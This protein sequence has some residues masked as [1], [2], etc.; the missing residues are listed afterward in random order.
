V[1]PG[2]WRLSWTIA[3]GTFSTS[4]VAECPDVAPECAQTVIE[5]HE[6]QARLGLTHTELVAAYGLA[7]DV[8][9]HLIVPYDVKAMN[10]RYT[11]LDGEPF[12]PP[13]GDIHHRTETLRGISDAALIVDWR[14]RPQWVAG[15]GVSLPVGRTEE[16]PVVLGR[17]GKQHQHIQFGSGTVQPRLSLQYARPGRVAL[18]GRGEARLSLYEN[19]EGFRAP[20]ALLW[21]LGPST[22][23]RGI[24]IDARF[25]G[26]HQTLGRWNG[27]IDEGSGFT[28]GGIRLGLS[29]PVGELQIAP[30]L[31]REAFSRGM[32]DE[33]FRQGTTWS[34]A[35]SR[36]F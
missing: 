34:L 11:T 24:G 22:T 16:N 6:H 15:L 1:A 33:T 14:V 9:M 19:G 12:V 13:Y 5:P 27:E 7:E 8:Q 18:F 36:T 17:E 2:R 25:E 26:Q 32:H 3:H 10:I 28:N 4:H 20:T 35:V 21:S 23:V 30:S 29:F 31:Y